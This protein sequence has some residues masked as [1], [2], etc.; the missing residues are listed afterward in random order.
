MTSLPNEDSDVCGICLEAYKDPMLLPC[1]HK[2]CTM[3]LE[4]W[5]PS[6]Y[7]SPSRR[8]CPECRSL[9]P[10]TREMLC[11]H[12]EV[13]GDVEKVKA[14]LESNIVLYADGKLITDRNGLTRFSLAPCPEFRHELDA[15]QLLLSSKRVSGGD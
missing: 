1:T 5:R 10:P 8:T 9:I 14:L 7:L 15:I 3:C 13:W 4:K 6:T 11:M 2:F 12:Q